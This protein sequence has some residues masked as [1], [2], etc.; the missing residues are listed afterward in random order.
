M[1][2]CCGWAALLGLRGKSQQLL[3]L[4]GEGL[5][6]VGALKR[7]RHVGQQEAEL[8]AAVEAPALI[9]ER[10][11][12]LRLD[13]PDHGVGDLDLAAGAGLLGGEDV[14]Y[15]GLENVAAENGEVGG[16]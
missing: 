13:Q 8:R 15:L 14:E 10:I 16:R 6:E 3:Q 1:T 2:G 12:G 11:K 7:V 4:G 5:A 9:A